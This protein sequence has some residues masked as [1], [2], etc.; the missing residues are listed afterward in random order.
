MNFNISADD[1]ADF[2]EGNPKNLGKRVFWKILISSQ[3]DAD[4]GDYLLRDSLHIGVK[5]GM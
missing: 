4:R 3:L 2:I 5:Y 1:L